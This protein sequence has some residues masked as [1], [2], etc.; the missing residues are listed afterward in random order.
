MDF[1][2]LLF[3]DGAAW[4]SVPALIGTGGYALRLLLA[5]IGVGGDGDSTDAAAS[6]EGHADLAGAALSIQGF[7]TFLMGFGWGGL[8]GYRGSDLSAGV[9]ALL[10]VGCG[11]VLVAVMVLLLQASRRLQSSGNMSLT[12]LVGCE[13]EACTSIPAAGQGRGQIVT[14]IG[15]RQR[16][17]YAVADGVEIPSRTRVAVVRTNGDNTVTVRP[18]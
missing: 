9:S 1:L 16:F 11:L 13:G 6:H 7:L 18:L 10:G 2:D 14:V 5:A 12:Q 3:S 17:A 4:F 15:D 8:G